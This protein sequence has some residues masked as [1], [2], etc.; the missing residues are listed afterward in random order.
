MQVI[1]VIDLMNGAVVHAR[2]GDRAHYQPIVSNL[3]HGSEASEIVQAL[4]GLYPFPILY[5]A[6]LDAIQGRGHHRNLIDTLLSQHPDLE[7]WIDAGISS[8]ADIQHWKHARLR[9]V[10]GT[11]SIPD[12]ATW[13]QLAQACA[14]RH[15]LSLDFT[16][17]GYQ[18]PPELLHNSTSWPQD[19]IVMSLPHVGSH[20]GPDMDK[21]TRFHSRYPGHCIYAAGGIRH[22]G[23]LQLLGGKGIKGALIASALHNGSLD[24]SAL[25]T[26]LAS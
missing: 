23:D 2:K 18:G 24:K 6:D 25:R 14:S 5:I 22:L 26:L 13:H 4:L 3:C 10:L 20:N 1:P 21:L 8:V 9:P 16:A 19:V 11:E 15:I 17:A 7:I 12:L